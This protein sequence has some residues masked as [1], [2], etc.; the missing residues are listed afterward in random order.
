MS[1]VHDERMDALLPE[2]S[3]PAFSKVDPTGVATV[4]LAQHIT[5][6]EFIGWHQNQVNMIRHEAVR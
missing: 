2:V 3:A 5:Q 6:P 1:L 4:R